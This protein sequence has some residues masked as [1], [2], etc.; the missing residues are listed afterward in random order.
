[1]SKRVLIVEDER[2]LAR[3]LSSALREAGYETVVAHTAEQGGHHWLQEDTFDLVIL[4]NRLPKKSGIE[5]LQEARDE[6]RQTK[7]ILMTAFDSRGVKGKAKRLEVDHY[8]RKPFDLDSI[9][10]SVSDLIG[11]P[12]NG[13]SM[14]LKQEGGD[15]THGKEESYEEENGQTENR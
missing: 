3:T 12:N 5:L 15:K 11:N 9:L 8:L 1:M 13:M 14:V 7:V 10:A 6:G 4:D 2:L